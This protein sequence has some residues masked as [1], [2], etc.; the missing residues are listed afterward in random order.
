MLGV[1]VGR[2]VFVLVGVLDGVPLVS[3]ITIVGVPIIVVVFVVLVM[4]DLIMAFVG[5]DLGGSIELPALRVCAEVAVG[6][7][8]EVAIVDWQPDNISM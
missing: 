1:L 6:C 7:T 3:E 8:S 4:V 2:G 5:E